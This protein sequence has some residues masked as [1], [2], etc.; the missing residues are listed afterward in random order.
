MVTH[1]W[2]GRVS[3]GQPRLP[4]QESE[5]RA[6]NNF[7]ALLYLC[8]HPLTQNEKIWHGNQ[9]GEG[10]VL[11]VQ[12][13][14]CVCTNASRGLS[15]IAKYLVVNVLEAVQENTDE[16]KE[17]TEY[18]PDSRQ[19]TAPD[20]ANNTA[21]SQSQCLSELRKNISL[22]RKVKSAMQYTQKYTTTFE[23]TER[24]VTA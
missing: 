15:A 20:T 1:V 10:R 23:E 21:K 5:V 4:S 12:P 14:H 19:T 6:L 18:N 2:E 22:P 24:N 16:E 3:L 17:Q 9:Y 7:G 13:H 11:G 8:L